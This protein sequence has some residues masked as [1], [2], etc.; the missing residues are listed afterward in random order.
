MY[1]PQIQSRIDAARNL[2][3]SESGKSGNITVTIPLRFGVNDLV[4]GPSAG[5]ALRKL[6]S[7]AG[8]KLLNDI[9]GSGLLPSKRPDQTVE[10]FSV[11]TLDKQVLNNNKI[12]FDLTHVEDINNVLNGTGEHADKITGV[13]L[14]HIKSNWNRFKGNVKFYRN[15]EEVSAPW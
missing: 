10:D 14:R 9:D 4:Y 6:Q 15:G 7:A 1:A 13:E 3:L 11:Q 2:R 8:G 12:H 5:G